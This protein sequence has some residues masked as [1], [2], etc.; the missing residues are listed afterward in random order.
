MVNDRP[1]YG[2]AI[3]TKHDEKCELHDFLEAGYQIVV[4]GIKLMRWCYSQTLEMAILT[5]VT[6]RTLEIVIVTS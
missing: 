4:D 5:L 1:Q 6:I 3:I 2:D